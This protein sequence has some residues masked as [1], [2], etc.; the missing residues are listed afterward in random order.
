[1]G[2]SRSKAVYWLDRAEEQLVAE[3]GCR[4]TDSELLNAAVTGRRESRRRREEPQP[5]QVSP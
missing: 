1:V 4:F 2:F 5:R 3:L